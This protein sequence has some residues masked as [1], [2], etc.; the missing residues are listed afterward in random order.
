MGHD[1]RTVCVPKNAATFIQGNEQSAQRQQA[2]WIASG[3]T[4][5]APGALT[6]FG[7]ALP[8]IEDGTS[9]AHRGFHPWYGAWPGPALG[10][11]L[12]ESVMFPWQKQNSVDAARQAFLQTFGDLLPSWQSALLFGFPQ[13][14]PDVHS[15]ICFQQED[16][17]PIC[18]QYVQTPK[19]IGCEVLRHRMGTAIKSVIAGF[20]IGLMPLLLSKVALQ[21][22]WLQGM[23]EATQFLLFPGAVLGYVLTLGRIHDISQT[24]MMGGSC[25]F[26]SALFYFL[27]RRQSARTEHREVNG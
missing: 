23:A 15:K 8:T 5:I 14:V 6:A 22:Q 20:A 27:A 1:G 3:H 17:P 7:N 18:Q 4:G 16:G 9:P 26:Y 24:V 13:T 10:H 21:T 19:G 25:A 11:V 2:A 12:R